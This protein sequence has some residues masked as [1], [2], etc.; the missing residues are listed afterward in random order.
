[1]IWLFFLGKQRKML[2]ERED[3]S[4]CFLPL[5]TRAVKRDEEMSVWDPELP[6]DEQ[7]DTAVVSLRRSCHLTLRC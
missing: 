7:R 1:M 2:G 4:L 3:E 6:V 5:G